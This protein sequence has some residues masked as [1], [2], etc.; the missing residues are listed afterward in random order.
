MIIDNIQLSTHFSIFESFNFLQ[1][2]T[3]FDEKMSPTIAQLEEHGTVEICN[4]GVTG[5]NPVGRI[6]F[7]FFLFFSFFHLSQQHEIIFQDFYLD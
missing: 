4:P 5:S 2:K 7:S 6:Y 3:F 1:L